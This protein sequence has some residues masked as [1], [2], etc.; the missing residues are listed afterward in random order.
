MDALEKDRT[1]TLLPEH[2]ATIRDALA[3]LNRIAAGDVAGEEAAQL[4]RDAM[5]KVDAIPVTDVV[6]RGSASE[7]DSGRKPVSYPVIISRSDKGALYVA[8][9]DAQDTTAPQ[10]GL[11]LEVNIGRPCV[12]VWPDA[13]TES[14]S[15]LSIFGEP[16]DGR[17]TA[18]LRTDGDVGCS[19]E[20]WEGTGWSLRPIAGDAID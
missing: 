14:S 10:L 8:F 2:E 4:A 15:V 12:H 19:K 11:L 18:M 20:N 1:T 3:L 7:W 16:A 5:D 17:F 6:Y 13:S 9:G